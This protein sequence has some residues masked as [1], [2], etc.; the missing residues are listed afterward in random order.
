MNYR[1]IFAQLGRILILSATFYIFP[2]LVALCYG[3]FSRIP[4]FLISLGVSLSLGCILTFFAK[5][6][7]KIHSK[8]GL[9]IVG[10]S[11]IIISAI[12]ALPLCLSGVLPNYIDAFFEMV[13]GFTTTGASVLTD[14]N[15][16]KCMHFW[17]A[18]S[19]WLGGMGILVFMLA[20]LPSQ[21]A[22]AFQLMKFES[23][24]PQVG[25][26][27]SKVRFTATI[28]YLIYFCFTVLEFLFLVFGGLDVYNSLI[29]SMSTAGTGGFAA[30]AGSIKDFDSLYVEI[31]VTVFM[32]IFSVNF[33]LYYL[34]LLKKFWN[35]LRDEEL[36]C[37]LLYVVAAILLISLNNTLQNPTYKGDFFK[38][39]RYSAF[40]VLSVSSTTGFMSADFAV[41][42][43]FSQA[44]L[45]VLMLFGSMAGSTGGGMKASRVLILLKSG[46]A[47][48]NKI[49]RPRSVYCVQMNKKE[50]STDVI[51]SVRNYFFLS[52][53]ILGISV[54]L[55]CLDGKVDFITSIS[56]CLTCFSNVGP[57]L[58]S[59][60]GPTGSFASL[61]SPTKLLLSLDMLLGRL[62][63]FP[64]LLLFSVK[65]W[66]KRY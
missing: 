40:A 11:W 16:A 42:P 12:G 65:T 9:V 48:A 4:Y 41:W 50:L 32:F 54:L 58:G 56:A 62:E 22:S 26:M 66:S 46:R 61:S 3:E 20:V 25:K 8:E 38:S 28:L 57:G 10:L 23:P 14:F 53:A 49:L 35:V 47:D 7:T 21:D 37:Y 18:F 60:I 6:Q 63:I 55:V 45:L 17:R 19:H 5:K 24:G 43:L 27:V 51:S 13:S 44:V 52:F 59:I 1:A 31:V 36:H 64:I 33:N 2:V 15:I 30:T 29:V 39:L 34:I